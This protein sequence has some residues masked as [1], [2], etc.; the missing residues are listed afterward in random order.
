MPESATLRVQAKK[1]LPVF[2]RMPDWVDRRVVQIKAGDQTRTPHWN[3]GELALGETKAGSEV[4][5]HFEQVRRSTNEQPPGFG[6]Y[7]IQWLGDTIVAMQP[8]EGP[9]VL[10]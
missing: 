1:S 7:H 9:I 6:E 4:T 8:H 10:Y 5:V 2:L 3:G